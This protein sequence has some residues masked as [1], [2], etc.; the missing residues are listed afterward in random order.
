MRQYAAGERES[1]LYDYQGDVL[2]TIHGNLKQVLRYNS[3]GCPLP[4][5]RRCTLPG[6]FGKTAL[7]SG[8][9]DFA[10]IGE[11]YGE[12][13]LRAMITTSSDDTIL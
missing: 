4:V 2:Q 9:A 8:I 6:A 3:D 5:S 12:G 13:K 7:L 11:D 10:G 1:F